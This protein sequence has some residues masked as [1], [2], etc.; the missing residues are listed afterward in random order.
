MQRPT[1]A[2]FD[3]A[4]T[5]VS[6]KRFAAARVTATRPAELQW[7]RDEGVAEEVEGADQAPWPSIL[8]QWG[9][10]EGVAEEACPGSR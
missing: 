6:R 9:R 8:L 5:R 7:G 4:A 1:I 2:C 10:D 3:G